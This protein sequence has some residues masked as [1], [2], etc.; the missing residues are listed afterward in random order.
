MSDAA[1][2][3]RPLVLADLVPRHAVRDVTL[4]V[5][6]AAF[7]GLAAQ[8][9]FHIPGTPVPVTGQTFAVLLAGAALGWW[10]AL[11]SMALYLLAG[12]AGL[13]WYAAHGS[14]WGGPSF[15]YVVGF[16]LAATVVGY[17][18][19]RGGDRTPL[20]TFATMAA[21]TLLIYAVGVPWLAASLHVGLGKAVAL[22]ARPF[23]GGDALKA[24]AA[25]GL[26]PAAW[27]LVSRSTP[28]E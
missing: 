12:A 16:V 9:S 3:H 27:R 11:L 1:V 15:G 20:R 18:A 5:A 25:A 28:P 26:L 21:G 24:A 8:V 14:G 10:R 23:L 7:V 2:V 17:L 6:G 13:P 22:G 4:V 19:G